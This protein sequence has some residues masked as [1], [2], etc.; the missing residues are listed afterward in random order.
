[1]KRK[2]ENENKEKPEHT[3]GDLLTQATRKEIIN[4]L[5]DFCASDFEPTPL[6]DVETHKKRTPQ[7]FNKM[8]DIVLEAGY[9]GYIGIEYEGTNMTEEEGVKATKRLLEKYI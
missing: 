3:L 7:N 5:A 1:M 8:I 4:P 2:K 9:Q 6:E